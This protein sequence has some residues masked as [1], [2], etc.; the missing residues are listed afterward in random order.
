MRRYPAPTPESIAL[1]KPVLL[2]VAL[3][4]AT[5]GALAP[6]GA[7]AASAS[8]AANP[9]VAIIV[10]ATHSV[11][12]HYRADADVMYREAIKY[13]SN[14]VRVYSPSATWSKVKAAVNGAS[15]VIYMGHGNGWPSPYGNDAAYTTKDG[16]GLNYDVNGDGKLSDYELKYYG[17]PSIR[18]LTPAPNAVVLLFHLCYASGDSEPD[19]AQPS[20]SVAR[21]RA[22]NFAAAFQAAGARAVL[23]IGLENDPYYVR[24][25]FTTRQTVKD[26]FLNAPG[27]NNHLFSFASVRT[28]GALELL[29]PESAKPADFYRSFVGR[30]TLRTEDVTGASYA[31]TAGDPP[32][33]VV[34]GNA[35]PVADGTPVYGT[36]GDAVAGSNPVTV[37]TAA[38]HVRVD[39]REAATSVVDHSPIYR[40]HADG[41]GQAWMS[42]AT[43]VPRD[44]AAPR[45][46]EVMDGDGTFSPNGDGSGD[47][48]T[49]SVRQSEVTSW[50]LRFVDGGGATL[51]SH[52]GTADTATITWAPAAGS[53]PDGDA[54]WRLTATDAWGNGPLLASGTVTVDTAA[55]DLAVDGDAAAI[56]VFSPNGD[57]SA[58][59]VKYVVR[60]TE[61]GTAR[62]TIRDAGGDVVDTV[63]AALAGG[64]ATLTWN[65]HD[66]GG[67]EV[68][69]GT[70]D[71]ELG[72]MDVAGNWSD[73]ALR[74]ATVFGSLGWV[75][76]SHAVFFPQDGDKLAPTTGLSFRLDAPATVTWTIVNAAGAVVRT[77]RTGEALGA[78]AY[79]FTWN[80]R[81]DAGAY[82]PRGTYRSVVTA[83]DGTRSITQRAA[84]VA[85]AF[86]VIASD[87]TPGRR[88][89][90]T[91]TA[92][93]AESLDS[94]PKLT[95]VQPG[96][97][98][99]SVTM[100]RSSSGTFVATITLRSSS[101]GTL[102][103]KVAAPDA[104]AHVQYSNLYLPLH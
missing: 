65:G 25:L 63:D 97:R 70:Y 33:M 34:P 23:A 8:V 28:P 50:T 16:F 61:P 49:V 71:V 102:R 17:E 54:T 104:N 80:G 93:T 92:I 67:A 6:S 39:A 15:I 76:A 85:D 37:V 78:G 62:A 74:Q 95:V 26:M 40:M 52:S 13:T 38:T 82:V 86:R 90:I 35:S 101:A 96:I 31:S 9:K 5:L 56:P 14:V 79:A 4:V 84:V 66:A 72:V 22:D 73:P 2:L 18:T 83:T 91:V 51:A 64:S 3:L 89:R 48:I 98:A 20:L 60:S 69:D 36:L 43:L 75:A 55:P 19:M 12:P 99:W 7:G 57:G 27:F 87:T 81:D 47:A 1:R 29:D 46:W 100:T 42:G 58:D 88:Q 53:V 77:I 103:L 11:T 41:I 68:P 45:A 24:S 32:T 10:G 21:Q 94:A 44:S 59:S 30:A